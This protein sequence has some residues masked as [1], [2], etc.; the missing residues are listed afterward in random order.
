MGLPPS[1]TSSRSTH[2]LFHRASLRRCA[3]YLVRVQWNGRYL[4]HLESPSPT[5]AN[6]TIAHVPHVGFEE[7]S[8]NNAQRQENKP[9]QMVKQK[10]RYV[11]HFL[12][13]SS[14]NTVQTQRHH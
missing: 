13:C 2:E 4:H 3:G 8:W 1:L 5:M 12:P 11:G 10:D 7:M 6:E 9:A 14:R